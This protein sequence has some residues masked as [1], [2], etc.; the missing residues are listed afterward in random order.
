[1]M[2]QPIKVLIV[3]DD[4]VIANDL[5]DKLE[6]AGH[7]VVAIS[8]TLPQALEAVRDVVP[9]VAILD[10]RLENSSYDGISIATELLKYHSFPIIYLTGHSEPD[11]IRRAKE[12]KPSAYLLKPYKARELVLQVE[13][14]YANRRQ[15]ELGSGTDSLYLPSNKGYELLLSQEVVF[16]QAEGAYVRVFLL[17]EKLPRVYSMPL[18]RLVEHFRHDNFFRISRSALINL[19]YLERL[20]VGQIWMKGILHPIPIPDTNRSEL[21]KRIKIVKTS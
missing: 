17:H 12:T 7:E 1:M 6:A 15:T 13:L 3:E 16:M 8:R 18:G 11:T 21:A 2:E 4:L 20:E 14:A 19:N 10:I 9:D 5:Q